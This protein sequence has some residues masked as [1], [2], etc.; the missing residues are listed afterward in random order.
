MRKNKSSKKLPQ[1]ETLLELVEF[2]DRHD[3]GEYWNDMPEASFDVDIKTRTHFVAID[4]DLAEKLTQIA[5][6]RRISSEKLIHS[7]LKEKINEQ[8]TQLSA[9]T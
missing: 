5:K 1:F 2:F 8:A 3:M 7:W 4:S 9:T 6:V